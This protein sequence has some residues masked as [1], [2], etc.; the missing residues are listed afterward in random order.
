M[1]QLER[2]TAVVRFERP[3]VWPLLNVIGLGFIHDAGLDSLHAQG[4]PEQVRD[5]DTWCLFFGQQAFDH[6]GDIGVGAPGI[7]KSRR[8]EGDYEIEETETGAITRT[9]IDN[10]RKYSMPDFQRYDV[11]DWDSWRV[12]RN[13]TAP[14]A[15]ATEHLDALDDCYRE[16]TR[17]IAVDGGSTWG[18]IRNWM[19]P[20]AALMALNDQPD[21]IH[22][23]MQHK[24]EQFDAYTAPVIDRLRP[25]IVMVWEDFCYNHGMMIGPDSFREFCEPYYRRVV[26]VSRNAGVPLVIVD[27]DGDVG[28]FLGL[29]EEVGVNGTWPLEVVCGNDMSGYRSRH[30]DMVL[31]GGI[32]KEVVNR[33]NGE[34]IE[35]ELQ[36][37]QDLLEQ[38]GF[39]PMFDHALQPDVDYKG[40]CRCMT[41][42]HEISG[43]DLGYFPRV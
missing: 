2:F 34:M 33:G 7:R 19:G 1:N 36:K 39:F 41:M 26:E 11:R 14:T 18:H 35:A 43:S 3:D 15:G 32:E 10:T 6:L 12:F 9:H 20:E 17:P 28:E 25:E 40:L 22:A 21:L 8:V 4:L 24:R 42:L 16:R 5:L 30:P 31:A 29:C 37:V 23:M 38:G 27:S 13:L